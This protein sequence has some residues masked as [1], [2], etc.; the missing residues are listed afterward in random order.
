MQKLRPKKLLL[1]ITIITFIGITEYIGVLPYAAA[2]LS[3]SIYVAVNY[4]EKGFKFQIAEYAYGFGDYFVRYNDKDGNAVGLM[5][6]PKEFPIFI[7]YDSL[8]GEG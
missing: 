2:R 4:P 5:L 1:I 3:S 7:R 8:K 6:F